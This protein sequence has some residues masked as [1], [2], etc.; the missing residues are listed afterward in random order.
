MYNL[1][2]LLLYI[3]D[4]AENDI[5][6]VAKNTT[7]LSYV[8]HFYQIS[9]RAYTY[10]HFISTIRDSEVYC[11]NNLSYHLLATSIN[12]TQCLLW[13]PSFQHYFTGC[14]NTQQCIITCGVV[15]SYLSA[16]KQQCMLTCRVVFSYLSA[17][18]Q[19]CMIT[20]GVVCSYLSADKQQN[21]LIFNITLLLK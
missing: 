4:R 1:C 18:K 11:Y 13:S 15:C 12:C 5:I 9:N 7:H 19:Q 3:K 20:C 8:T 14:L 21:H 10:L 16:D 2:S 6:H 17:D